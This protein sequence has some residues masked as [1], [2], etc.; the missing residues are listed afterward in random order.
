MNYQSKATMSAFMAGVM[1]GAF[2][3]GR[4]ADMVGRRATITTTVI[5]IGLFNTLSGLTASFTIYVAAKFL[6]GFFCAGNILAMFVLG[7]ELV[8]ASKR[9]IVGVTMQAAFAA[10]I[11]LFALVGWWIQH[12]RQLTLAISLPCLPA[13][14]LHWALPESPRWLLAQD[15]TSEA[16]KVL[17]VVVVTDLLVLLVVLV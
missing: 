10:G 3:L 7:N 6:V 1:V 11:V 17:R 4:L 2:V 9:G 16:V 5:G 13:L 14:L 15:R 8:G 12:W